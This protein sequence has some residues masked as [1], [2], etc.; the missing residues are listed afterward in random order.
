MLGWK[1]E[2]SLEDM[3]RDSFHWQSK[4]PK[5]YA[6]ARQK[7]NE[8]ITSGAHGFRGDLTEMGK[9]GARSA[10]PKEYNYHEGVWNDESLWY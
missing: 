7:Q 5:G 2:H 1:A 4:N 3:C 9:R 8:R 6:G 10:L